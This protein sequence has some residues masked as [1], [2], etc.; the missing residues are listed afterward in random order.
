MSGTTNPDNRPSSRPRG[1]LGRWWSAVRRPLYRGA[2][3]SL[4]KQ[5][6]WRVLLWLP[7]VVP[8]V[9]VLA[10]LGIYIALGVRARQLAEEGMASMRAKSYAKAQRQIMSAAS[11]RPDDP[12]VR[13]AK[14][15]LASRMNDTNALADWQELATAVN[16]DTEEREEHARLAMLFGEKDEFLAAAGALE[17]RGAKDK[18]ASFRSMRALRGRDLAGAVEEARTAVSAGGDEET[19]MALLRLLILRHAPTLANA[20]SPST[21]DQEALDEI[22]AIVDSLEGRPPYHAAVAAALLGVPVPPSR[23]LAWSK[24]AV[25]DLSATNE[26]LLPAA[27]VLIALRGEDATE[28]AARLQPVFEKSALDQ[29]IRFAQWLNLHRQSDSVLGLLSAEEASAD[30]RAYSA[31]ADALAKM[32][33]W[34]PLYEMSEMSGGAPESLR[35]ASRAMAARQLGRSAEVPAV[36]ASALRAARSE[37]HLQDILNTLDRAGEDVLLDDILL[38]MC[39]EVQNVDCFPVVRQRLALRGEHAMLDQAFQAAWQTKPNLPAVRD[40]ALRR[41]LLAGQEVDTAETAAAVAVDPAELNPRLTH[42]LN[43]LRRGEAAE[44]LAVFDDIDVYVSQLPPGDQAIVYAVQKANAQALEAAA[45]LAAIERTKLTDEES[46][47][48]NP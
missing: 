14:T 32:E 25:G 47:L 27:D 18:A 3:D 30:A 38:A 37:G 42:A 39:A 29:R 1:L 31:R 33:Q 12:A 9:A 4:L 46:A 7:V 40:Y 48:L 8:V 16:L 19:K 24:S 13:R 34:Q 36:M 15:Y 23:A 22:L 6:A 28:W 44:A 2:D 41:K 11:L 43:L 17:A 5:V 35:L 10:G 21:T 26:A 20:P 45:L